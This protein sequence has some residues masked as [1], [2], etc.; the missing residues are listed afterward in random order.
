VASSIQSNVFAPASEN[1]ASARVMQCLEVWGGNAAAAETI[2]M[3]GLDAWVFSR[4]YAGAEAGGDV[5]YLSSCGTGRITR[6][7][8]ADVS[9][10]GEAVAATAGRL[11]SMMRRFVNYVDQTRFVEAMNR[12]FLSLNEMGAFATSVVATY[13]GP[14]KSLDVCNA[15][16]PRPLWYRASKRTWQLLIDLRE[17]DA[18]DRSPVNLPLGMIE[19]TRYEQFGVK[20]HAGDL[21]LI[22]TDSLI[23]A[24]N[25]AGRL[26]GE[27]GLLELVRGLDASSP[28][29]LIARLLDRVATFRADEPA[30]DDVTALLLHHH[31]RAEQAPLLSKLAGATRF[32]G[33]L[34]TSWLPNAEPVP[35]PEFNLANLGGPF[36]KAWNRRWARTNP[37]E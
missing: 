18:A 19:P 32:L 17:R 2:A 37:D 35:W 10:H 29:T 14:T 6:V 25:P 24:R 22:Y 3:P 21:V 8:L 34:A 30:D 13:W 26:L 27:E 5:H 7:L 16:H 31:G 4:P 15:G 23:E 36:L 33:R 1:A 20:L 11:R 28:A 12:E 9:G